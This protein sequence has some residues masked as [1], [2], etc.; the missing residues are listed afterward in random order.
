MGDYARKFFSPTIM[1]TAAKQPTAHN[2][3]CT[4]LVSWHGMKLSM[5]KH[6]KEK[7]KNSRGWRN[8]LP[9][10]AKTVKQKDGQQHN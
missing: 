5:A 10:I 2:Q 1:E 6:S 3:I 8:H 4:G 7:R 9:I